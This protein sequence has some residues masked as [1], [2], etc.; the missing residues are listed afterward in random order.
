MFR[1][2]IPRLLAVAALIVGVGAS[3][4]VI[5][6]ARA[7][8]DAHW[9]R[10]YQAGYGSGYEAGHRAGAVRATTAAGRV[11]HRY[12]RGGSGWAAIFAAGRRDGL[13]FGRYEGYAAGHLAG[14][15]DAR[16]LLAP[17][18]RPRQRPRGPS[19]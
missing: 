19:F 15:R 5:G 16:L 13:R 7:D 14:L 1:K 17:R 2:V 8:T 12:R 18:P 11:L 3:A 4:Y 10:G 9:T 6:L